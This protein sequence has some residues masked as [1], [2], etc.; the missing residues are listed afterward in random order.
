MKMSNQLFEMLKSD[1]EVVCSAY[2]LL[3]E[4]IKTKAGAWDVFHAVCFQRNMSDKHPHF[5]NGG[6]RYLPFD[7]EGE[8]NPN[9]NG[10]PYLGRFYEVEDLN[11]SHI[12]TALKRI[13]P[14]AGF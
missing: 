7:Q 2:D 3:T 9:I 10:G 14:N 13:M 6:T 5:K 11:D 12:A 1:C 4:D 8:D